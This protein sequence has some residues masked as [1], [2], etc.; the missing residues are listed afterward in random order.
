MDALDDT[1]VD[2]NEARSLVV[3]DK[4]FALGGRPENDITKIITDKLDKT[5]PSLNLK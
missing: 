4:K 5:L 3:V 2:A 1:G